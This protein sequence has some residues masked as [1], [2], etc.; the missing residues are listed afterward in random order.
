MTD[1]QTLKQLAERYKEMCNS[2]FSDGYTFRAFEGRC[3][4]NGYTIE[5]VRNY[6]EKEKQN[7]K[8]ERAESIESLKEQL[9]VK[10][11]KLNKI[12]EILEIH[13]DNKCAICH[14]FDECF[15][16]PYCDNIILQIIEDKNNE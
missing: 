16:H 1:K 14:K 5:D 7:R 10:E 15:E 13:K 2:P 8:V 11:K 4:E 6:I 3:E 12:K 9:K